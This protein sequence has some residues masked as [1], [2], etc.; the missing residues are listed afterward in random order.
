M[1]QKYSCCMLSTRAL[2]HYIFLDYSSQNAAS[3][4]ANEI[5]RAAVHQNNFSEVLI[6]SSEAG[7]HC[8]SNITEK[9][10]KAERKWLAYGHLIYA[11]FTTSESGTFQFMGSASPPYLLSGQKCRDVPI[12]LC[13]KKTKQ[14][15]RM[16]ESQDGDGKGR[17]EPGQHFLPFS[18]R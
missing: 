10:P 7:Q 16:A 17:T 8:L 9:A 5:L 3:S 14:N 11:W 13:L 12:I 2:K 1:V 6:F 4:M 18:P 15:K